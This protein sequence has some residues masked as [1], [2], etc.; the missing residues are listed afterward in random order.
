MLKL[1]KPLS[2]ALRLKGLGLQRLRTMNEIAYQ[3][4][5]L[6]SIDAKLEEVYA[7]LIEVEKDSLQ[8]KNWQETVAL[9]GSVSAPVI[10]TYTNGR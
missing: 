5:M 9:W 1:I 2:I 8:Q 4:A 6:A 7:E 10:K 3:T